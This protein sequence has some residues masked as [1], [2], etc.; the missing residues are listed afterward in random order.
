MTGVD[1]NLGVSSI[2]Q[3]KFIQGLRMKEN[4]NFEVLSLK[5]HA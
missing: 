4:I 2:R 5:S 1:N 3:L